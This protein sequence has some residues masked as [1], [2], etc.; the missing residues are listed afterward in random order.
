[1]HA[2]ILF[3]K[4][5]IITGYMYQTSEYPFSHA[6]IGYPISGYPL[7]IY[8]FAKHNGCMQ[9]ITFHLSFLQ[10][11]FLFCHWLFMVYTKTSLSVNNYC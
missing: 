10:I 11:K 2:S 1:M 6:L 5:W 9:A 3:C 4:P 8:W 7:D